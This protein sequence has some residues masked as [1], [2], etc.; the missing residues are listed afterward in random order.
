MISGERPHNHNID[1]STYRQYS[2]SSLN[3][4]ARARIMDSYTVPRIDFKTETIRS[5]MLA[6]LK[7][8]DAVIDTGCG[9]GDWLMTL[10]EE[11][12]HTGLMV[13]INDS[14]NTFALGH[15]QAAEKK[16]DN[17]AF[18]EMDARYMDFPEN[19]FDAFSAQNFW[20]HVEDYEKAMEE[21]VR[22][23]K[24]GA[25]GI[26]ST[27]GD[28]HQ[29]RIWAAQKRFEKDLPPPAEDMPSPV[30]PD[31]FYHHFDAEEAAEIISPYFEI[32]P[33]LSLAQRTIVRIPPEG[34]LDYRQAALSY[35]DSYIPIPRGG[36]IQNLVDGEFKDI[37][38]REVAQKGYFID[39]THRVFFLCKNTVRK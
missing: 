30:A 24:P 12:G 20:Y 14:E 26:I 23:S 13:G 11:Y 38:D 34:W 1:L 17:L 18:T 15:E 2:G 22:T 10:A 37:F 4:N 28:F 19:T 35:K 21:L 7:K 27:K 29:F 33:E 8:D 31:V 25:I 9:E 6:G 32:V 5:L 16:I 36:D 39:Y 3:V